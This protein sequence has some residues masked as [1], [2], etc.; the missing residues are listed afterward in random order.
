MPLTQGQ[1]VPSLDPRK[2]T[3]TPHVATVVIA[4]VELAVS[5]SVQPEA[6]G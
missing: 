3:G 1:I 4:R 2:M 6:L 5:S